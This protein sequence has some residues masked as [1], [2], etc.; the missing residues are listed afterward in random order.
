MVTSIQDKLI[1]AAKD[2]QRQREHL[3]RAERLWAT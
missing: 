1:E 2:T 3:A